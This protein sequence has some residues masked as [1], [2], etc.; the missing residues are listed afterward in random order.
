MKMWSKIEP[1]VGVVEKR[2]MAVSKSR[3]RAVCESGG[4]P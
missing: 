2:N 1:V 3:E 4:N